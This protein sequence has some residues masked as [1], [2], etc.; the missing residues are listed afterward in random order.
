MRQD[1][2]WQDRIQ[3]L[4]VVVVSVVRRPC[5]IS[6]SAARGNLLPLASPLLQ[7]SLRDRPPDRQGKVRDLYELGDQL[8]IVATD[9]ISAFD[10]VLG[11]GIPDKGKVLTQ[12]SAF[13][14]DRTRAIVPNHVVSTD[15]ADLSRTRGGGGR[16]AA[17]PFDARQADRAAA[18]RMRRARLSRPAPAGRTTPPAARSAAFACRPGCASRNG[19]PSPSSRRPRRPQTGHDLNISDGAGGRAC[20]PAGPRPR[21]RTDAPSVRRRR[22]PRRVTRHH[23]RGHE[24]RVRPAARRRPAGRRGSA[25]PDRRSA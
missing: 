12:I 25:D 22:G 1:E 4:Q 13:W 16:L 2:L 7:T 19:F 3:I 17:R 18:D 6:G 24:V 10:Y 23:R 15:P 5:K 20:R 8:L 11:S 9:R 21:P 14:F